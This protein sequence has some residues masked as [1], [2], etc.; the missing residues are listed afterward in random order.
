[1]D[2]A[3]IFLP[4]WESLWPEILKDSH[5]K[6]DIK[7]DLFPNGEKRVH[8]QPWKWQSANEIVVIG[9][10]RDPQNKD[11]N[12]Y[13]LLFLWDALKRAGILWFTL[14]SPFLPYTRQDRITRPWE[15]IASSVVFKLLK[16]AWVKKLVTFNLHNSCEEWL[17]DGQ[18]IHI[19]LLPQL[20]KSIV[21]KIDVIVAPDVGRAKDINKLAT[22]FNKQQAVILK[23]RDSDGKINVTKLIG[24]IKNKNVAIVDDMID[25]WGTMIKALE[26]LKAHN[27]KNIY[28]VAV[29]WL[30]S[31]P[32][33]SRFKKARDKKLYNQLLISDT[34]LVKE[35]ITW[36]EIK[37]V[38]F[39][40]LKEVI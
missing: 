12:L 2:R 28:I 40:N 36:M 30:F 22:Q 15:P 17:F 27:A 35:R 8:I 24:D 37:K 21:D 5:Q 25:T 16:S 29:H 14:I 19:N 33:P 10:L 20:V 23:Q 31:S 34:I 3:F 4:W 1:M 18:I 13:Y 6:I 7:F 39:K 32:A 26:I 9:S 11:Q 38:V